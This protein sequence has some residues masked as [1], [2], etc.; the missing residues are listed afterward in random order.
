M[1][2]IRKRS[3]ATRSGEARAG[4]HPRAAPVVPADRHDRHPIA[5]PSREVDQL[6]VEDDA[7]DLLAREQVVGGLARKPLKPHCVSWTGPTTQIEAS[8]VERLAE[9]PPIA[10]LARPHVR[11]VGLD[12]RPERD[13]VVGQGRDQQRQLVGR[14]RHVGVGEDDEV[15]RRRP[16]CPLGRPRPCRRGAPSGR[17]RWT[18]SASG[19]PR[20]GP[21]TSAAVP[22]VLP[23]STTRTSIRSGRPAEPG[24]PSRA[25]SP[26]RREVAEQLVER[27]TDPLGLVVGGQDDGQAGSG[28]HAGSLRARRGVRVAPACRSRCIR[29]TGVVHHGG[30]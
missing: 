20:V 14:R 16:A 26:R 24:A 25:R 17:R 15:G 5:A 10:R 8:E 19:A 28:G 6:D 18:S 13:I 7:R 12:P 3:Q 30:R 2:G 29:R 27:R 22:S 9:Q 4:A 21:R 23:S 11:A 1:S